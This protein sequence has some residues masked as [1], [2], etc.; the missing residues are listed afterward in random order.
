MNITIEN[1]KGI[2]FDFGDQIVEIENI[3]RLK[4]NGNDIKIVDDNIKSTTNDDPKIIENNDD[5]E[6]VNNEYYFNR[7]FEKN[8]YRSYYDY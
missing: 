6:N 7:R 1:A 4:I 5:G 3:E 8:Y 2:H